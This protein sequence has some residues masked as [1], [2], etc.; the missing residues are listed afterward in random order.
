MAQ[1]F[2]IDF[3][4]KL[5]MAQDD[6]ILFSDSEDGNKIKKAQYKNLKWEDWN[7]V[8]SITSSKDWKTTTVTITETNGEVDTFQ[9]QDWADWQ[10]AWDVIWPDSSTDWHLVAFDWTSG[11]LIKD[12]W[13]MPTVP[14]KTSDLTNDSNFVDSSTLST[15][16]ASKQDTLTAGTGISITNNVIS[17]TAEWWNTKTFYLSSVGTGDLTTAQAVVDWYLAG[18]NP[19][20]VY[21]NK[22][23]VVDSYFW[24]SLSFKCFTFSFSNSN[25]SYNEQSYTITTIRTM[26]I[27]INE[28]TWTA[29]RVN[30]SSSQTMG[31]GYL[32][33]WVNY[34]TPYLPEY[35]GS[36]ATK[37]YVDNSVSVVSGDTGTKYTIKVSHSD[38]SWVANNV[39][40]FV[41]PLLEYSELIALNNATAIVNELNS[42]AS[43]YFNKYLDEWHIGEDFDPELVRPNYYYLEDNWTAFTI[44]W[45]RFLMEDWTTEWFYEG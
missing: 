24:N 9:I 3:E 10:W 17:S 28:S 8:E 39:I 26:D 31:K 13:I 43:W 7:W 5:T 1:I 40:T 44:D 22:A 21:T 18:K 20:I 42:D 15:A 41:T 16:L 23:F 11:K 45:R 12:W 37:K 33:P 30:Y 14:T 38:P 25:P 27:T 2:P 6:Y 32:A 35:D 19:I 4:E 36:P 29:T 34:S